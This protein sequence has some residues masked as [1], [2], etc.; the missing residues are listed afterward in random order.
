MPSFQSKSC[1]GFFPTCIHFVTS[2]VIEVVV[3]EAV[4]HRV[5]I[6]TNEHIIEGSR[7]YP[8][9]HVFCALM[10][11]TAVRVLSAGSGQEWA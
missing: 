2:H 11:A 6:C 10:E 4:P 1:E 5:G 7:G 9:V 8:L 3:L